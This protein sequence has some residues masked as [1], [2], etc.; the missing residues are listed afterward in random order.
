MS[1]SEYVRLQVPSARIEGFTDSGKVNVLVAG[2]GTGREPIEFA[3][4]VPNASILAIDLSLASLGYAKRKSMELGL[5]NIEYARGD[6]LKLDAIER[7]FDCVTAFGSLQCLAEPMHGWRVLLSRLLP[8]GLM[9]VGIY[10]KAGR[11]GIVAAQKM[12]SERGYSGSAEDIR[13]SRQ[14]IFTQADESAIS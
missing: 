6:I 1:L 10:R 5:K 14:Q 11:A 13:A 9:R 2:C 8:G 3:H 12:L 7:R 4:R